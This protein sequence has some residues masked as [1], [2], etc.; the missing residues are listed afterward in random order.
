M[1]KSMGLHLNLAMTVIFHCVSSPR[2]EGEGLDK[3]RWKNYSQLKFSTGISGITI[4]TCTFN[5]R[6]GKMRGNFSENWSLYMNAVLRE[7]YGLTVIF[8]KWKFL[9]TFN[10][11]SV[12]WNHCYEYHLAVFVLNKPTDIIIN[13]LLEGTD[14]FLKTICPSSSLI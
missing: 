4:Q 3:G 12:I 11:L 10:H 9:T 14:T 5:Q 2:R 6:V 8:P 13:V 7:T 1:F